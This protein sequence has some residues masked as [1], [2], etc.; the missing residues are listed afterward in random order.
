M[1]HKTAVVAPYFHDI[2]QQREVNA[3]G[4]WAFLATEVMFFG[5]LFMAYVV[6]RFSYPEGF[7]EG[8][9]E[10]NLLLGSIN[11]VIL[12][13]SSFTMA[14]AVHSAQTDAKRKL[15]MFL[16]LTILLGTVF[17]GI[18]GVEYYEKFAHH[19]V[20][21]PN[22][23]FHGANGNHVQLFISLYFATTG[24]HAIHMIIGVGVLTYFLIKAIMG[25]YNSLNY[26]PVE[27]VGLYWHFVDI[28]WVFIFP[29]Y[30][31][32]ERYLTLG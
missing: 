21:G 9:H 12:L 26:D 20:P 8:S 7:I 4:M 11:T 3:L 28:A 32:I 2:D 16:I 17:L 10:L 15:V 18:K 31:L 24:L 14:M 25:R 27:M 22:F 23:E 6:Y 30:Y 19:L 29:L 5:G 13:V 1:A